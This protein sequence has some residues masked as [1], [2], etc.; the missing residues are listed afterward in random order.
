MSTQSFTSC[1]AFLG[2]E[3]IASGDLRAVAEAAKARIDRGDPPALLIFDDVTS[4]PVELD[5]RGTLADVLARL[6][7]TAETPEGEA[8]E[9]AEARS[10]GR[11]KLG[12]VA[13]E[14]TL[15]PRHW[16]WLGTQ[17]GGASVTLRKLVE[18]ARKSHVEEDR[19]RQRREAAYRFM[20]AMGGNEVGFEEA[21]RALFAGQREPFET[22]LESW[23]PDVRQHVQ[24]LAGDAFQ[25]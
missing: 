7:V 20:T 23:P 16:E 6:P 19:L 11:P 18:A 25:A 24:A 4:Q 14:V 12:V 9:S 3:R 10:P 15:L 1:T 17:P 21:I 13:R 2:T 22:S 8:E 5:L